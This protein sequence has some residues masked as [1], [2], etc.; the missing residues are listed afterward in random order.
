MPILVLPHTS[1][2]WAWAASV[3]R[4]PGYLTNV[5]K[6]IRIIA[7]TQKWMSVIVLIVDA[8]ALH[9]ST[10]WDPKTRKYVG[11]ID[12]GTA[13]PEAEDELAKETLVFMV[14]GMSGHWKHPIAYVLQNACSAAVQSE[15]IKECIAVCMLKN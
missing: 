4:E 14:S 1:S 13:I 8:T 3:E 9:E 11:T 12:Y 15:L 10:M 7:Q 6:Q 2:I 5:I